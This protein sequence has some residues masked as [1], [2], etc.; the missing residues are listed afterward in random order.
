MSENLNIVLLTSSIRPDNG[1][2]VDNSIPAN[3]VTDIK[4]HSSRA[5]GAQIPAL[6]WA[7]GGYSEYIGRFKSTLS[8]YLTTRK[9]G[10]DFILLPHD[11]WGADGGQS[12]G[13]IFPGDNGNWTE[14]EVF[15][16]QVVN[17]LKEND[18]LGGLV[19]DLWNEPDLTGFWNRS[20]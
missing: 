15:L 7:G 3:F 20:W 2:D 17:D 6:G 9:Y 18:M 16:G 12:S 1:T 8:N 4:F 14:M 10:G 5:G 11:L 19:V 13:S